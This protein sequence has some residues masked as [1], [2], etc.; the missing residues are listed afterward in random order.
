MSLKHLVQQYD[1]I[2][3]YPPRMDLTIDQTFTGSAELTAMFR[4]AF[5]PYYATPVYN[6]FLAWAGYEDAARTITEGWAAKDREKTGGAMTDE[7]ID[8]IG[9]IGNEA[10]IQARIQADA[11]GGVHTHII[12]P[13]AG[14]KEDLDRTFEAF[15]AA[16]FKFK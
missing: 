2:G 4:A 1:A 5:G 8:E 10:E 6:K 12:A 14:N 3:V 15:T 13:L 9:I 7:M 16:A 11:D